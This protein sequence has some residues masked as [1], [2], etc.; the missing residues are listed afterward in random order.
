M[1][2]DP[3]C[4]FAGSYAM[5]NLPAVKALERYVLGRD[6]G[7]TS[8]TTV[9]Q[10]AHIVSSL[11]LGPHSHLLELG[12][13]SGWPGLY[14]S[15]TSGCQVTLLDLPLTALEMAG[16]RAAQDGLD[17]RVDLISATTTALPIVAA[18]FDCISHSDVLCCLEAKRAMLQECRRVSRISGRM[19][20]SVIRP[21][22]NLAGDDL[23]A[24]LEAGPP[25]VEV[26]GRYSDMLRDTGWKIVERIDV[27]AEF[28][29]TL[30]RLVNGLEAR[31][32]SLQKVFGADEFADTLRRRQRQIR[33]VR[34][35]TLQR[36]VFSVT[37]V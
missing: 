31:A 8:W 10:V 13:G 9:D 12:C 35:R 2:C 29:A 7:G 18:S 14:L 6:Y 15:S 20:F 22:H 23:A 26:P 25:F 16:E 34:A 30:E 24:A 1:N 11:R 5:S 36:Y 27:T 21:E 28:E 17:D 4:D 3:R 37:A 33:I 19:H 32:K